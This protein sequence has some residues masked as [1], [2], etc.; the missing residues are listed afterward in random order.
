MMSAKMIIAAVVLGFGA[1]SAAWAQSNYTT[2]TAASNARAGY[3]TGGYGRGLY[4]YAPGYRHDR[5]RWR[6]R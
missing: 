3:G 1:L 6:R 4:N 2:G 5:A